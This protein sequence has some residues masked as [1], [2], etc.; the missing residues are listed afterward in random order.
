VATNP[1]NT[2]DGDLDAAFNWLH[3]AAGTSL[4]TEAVVGWA[5]G[6]QDYTTN[7]SPVWYAVGNT[8]VYVAISRNNTVDGSGRK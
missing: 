8:T 1:T 4:T 5:P 2:A 7:G 6:S 3:A